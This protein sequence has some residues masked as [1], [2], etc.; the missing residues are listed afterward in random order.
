[1]TFSRIAA[2]GLG[3]LIIVTIPAC[4]VTPPTT[5]PVPSAPAGAAD[6]ATLLQRAVGAPPEQAARLRL[7]AARLYFQRT[8][9]I[10]ARSS[11]IS[12]RSSSRSTQATSRRHTQQPTG[13]FQ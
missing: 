13:Q 12:Y 6:P 3:L 10:D 2:L 5:A 9:A 1:M 8:D 11:S 4:Q 7:E